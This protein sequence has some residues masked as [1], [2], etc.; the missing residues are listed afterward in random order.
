M[1]D[2]KSY[3]HPIAGSTFIVDRGNTQYS[4]LM[5]VNGELRVPLTDEEAIKQL[6]AVVKVPSSM[7]TERVAT[8]MQSHKEAAELVKKSAEAAADK[9]PSAKTSA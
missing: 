9:A 5:F 8:T 2:T 1:S 6:D 7:I 4:T 3:F